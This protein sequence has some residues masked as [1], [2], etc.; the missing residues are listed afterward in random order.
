MTRWRLLLA[1]AAVLLAAVVPAAGQQPRVIAA[2]PDLGDAVSAGLTELRFTFDRDMRPGGRSVCGGGPGFPQIVGPGRWEG[3]RTF[4]LPVRLEPEN[5]YAL[6]VNCPA[7]RNFRSAEG[8]PAEPYPIQFRTLAAGEE[9]ARLGPGRA[10]E[11]AATLR[12]LIDERYSHRDVRGVDWEARFG[13]MKGRLEGAETPA[14][15]ARAAAELLRV[16]NDLHVTVEVDGLRLA[17]G[18]RMVAP[19]SDPGELARIVQGW[20]EVRGGA[21]GRFDD[22]IGYVAIHTWMGDEGAMD[23]VVKAIGELRAGGATGLVID[24]R[25]NSGG[26]EELARRV[27]GLFV[28]EKTVYSRSLI[29]DPSGENG[30]AGPFD[31][32]VEPCAEGERFAGK[33]AVLM[34]PACMST[35]ESFVLMMREDGKR[36]LFGAPSW[37]SSGNPRPH[38]IGDGV[39]VFLS[40]WVDLTPG[41][42]RVEGKGIAPDHA[43]EWREGPADPVLDAALAWLRGG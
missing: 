19:N 34:G 6:S 9:P 33:V 3:A 29:R 18:R 40:S 1:W 38:E 30:W 37:G 26:N 39:R 22:G 36:E 7:A 41:G 14:A 25:Q 15:F 4:V 28:E 24:V 31:R 10:A 43:V 12:R 8:E 20:R 27:A 35:C 32:V 23:E 42:D 2:A 13:E 11:M 16:N 21:R 5:R 17:T